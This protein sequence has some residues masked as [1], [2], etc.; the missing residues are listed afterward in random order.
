MNPENAPVINDWI[1][2]E[3][4]K[5]DALEREEQACAPVTESEPAPKPF[6]HVTLTPWQEQVERA[7]NEGAKY[8]L[9]KAGRKTGKSVYAR[10][11]LVQS[12]FQAPK[13]DDQTNSYIAP[14]RIQA[15]KIMWRPLK[16]YVLPGADWKNLLTS[17][18]NES[19]LWMDFKGS[20]IRL[21]IE[22]AENETAIRGWNMGETV[23]DE[24]DHIQNGSFFS[25]VVEPN[26][27]IT[28]PNVLM[29]STP[30]NRWF[31]KLWHKAKDGRLGR[32]WAAFHFTSY[33]NPYI[34]KDFLDE[35]KMN[36]PSHIWE[37]EYMANEN[38]M[39]GMKY[40]EFEGKH[41]V[42]PR[43]PSGQ[44]FLRFL[45][46]G[47]EHPSVCLWADLW[48]NADK[49][50]WCLYIF[51][52]LALR[53][54]DIQ[55]LSLAICAGDTRNY[56]ANVV[57]KAARRHEMGTGTQIMHEFAKNGLP[58]VLPP[59]KKDYHVNCLKTMLKNGDIE[60]S[61]ECRTL[62]KQLEEV[63]WQTK[64]GD[65]A[66]DALEYGTAW[67]YGR[68]FSTMSVPNEPERERIIAPGGLYDQGS[69][70]WG[71]MEVV[72]W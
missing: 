63:E 36:L 24:A 12:C 51:R 41:I 37:E 55:E 54:K 29:I 47:W 46:W 9:I 72:N 28:D 56:L 5:L 14:T 59:H 23:I 69:A 44:K 53:G 42:S 38:A 7:Y 20:G 2:E 61:R 35:K 40:P 49:N 6:K 43:S 16:T 1:A 11:R 18:P 70:S 21:S 71:G 34:N 33:D 57:D 17:K 30:K 64:E 67:V 8:I 22:G 15:K 65:D 68:D 62:I 50:R 48:F 60:I 10:Y 66:V 13:V 32:K 26:F 52:E 4:A 31:T 25:E 19:E 27:A 39:T 3:I 45:D 58:C